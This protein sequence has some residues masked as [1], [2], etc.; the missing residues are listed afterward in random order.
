MRL[1]LLL[2]VVTT[3]AV[4]VR[5]ASSEEERAP[6][7]SWGS[8]LAKAD[9]EEIARIA[10][11]VHAAGPQAVAGVLEALQS[12]GRP[13]VVGGSEWLPFDQDPAPLDRALATDPHPL[14]AIR[15]WAVELPDASLR[16]RQG[17]RSAPSPVLAIGEEHAMR[18][19]GGRDERA[20]RVFCFHGQ[21][22][23]IV[24][25]TETPYLMDYDPGDHRLPPE[26][27]IGCAREGT[28]ATVTPVA[29]ESGTALEVHVEWGVLHRPIPVYEV[30]LPMRAQTRI[31]LPEL[32]V[33]TVKEHVPVPK[34]GWV[35]VLPN[36]GFADD[37][38]W[39]AR[40]PAVLLH[41][42]VD[43]VRHVMANLE[44]GGYEAPEPVGPEHEPDDGADAACGR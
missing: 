9:A 7:G 24:D 34:T 23:R 6:V 20:R 41:V 29:H 12:S 10:A 38:G 30:A 32:Q 11:E 2:A 26:P 16:E 22:A 19:L 13:L 36:Q 15:Y 5:F 37:S 18:V 8:R 44:P 31:Q 43:G 42:S 1:V 28:V 3:C 14:V 33:Q 4:A 39:R 17:R 35:L 27:M 21:T 40:Q 25:V